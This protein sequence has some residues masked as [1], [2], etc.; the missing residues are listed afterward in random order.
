MTP[1]FWRTWAL[2]TKPQTG[3]SLGLSQRGPSPGWITNNSRG[4]QILALG[5]RYLVQR[6]WRYYYCRPFLGRRTS[7]KCGGETEAD[8]G[9]AGGE[10]PG[11]AQGEKDGRVEMYSHYS[12]SPPYAFSATDQFYLMHILKC[13]LLRHDSE[14][15]WTRSTTGV[16]LRRWTSSFQSPTRDFSFTSKRGCLPWRIRWIIQKCDQK[17]NKLRTVIVSQN[18]NL[19]FFCFMCPITSL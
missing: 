17:S 19:L 5:L 15:R 3:P 2:H 13:C 4:D 10:E 12:R 16:C 18:R 11:T 7:W 1:S 14:R 6:R 9:P 8:G